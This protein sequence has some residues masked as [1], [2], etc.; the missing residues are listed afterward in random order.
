MLLL[1]HGSGSTEVQL[2]SEHNSAIWSVL[3]R[4][5]LRYLELHGDKD[6]A[7]LLAETP[8]ELCH[9]TNGFGDEFEL[10]YLQT[11]VEGYLKFDADVTKRKNGPNPYRAIANALSELNNAIRFIVVDIAKDDAEAVS[12]PR[13]E[14]TS[15]TVER[16]L[17]DFEA[18]VSSRGGAVS[19]VDRIHTALHAYLETVCD[20]AGIQHNEGADIATLF[21]LIRQQHPKLQKHPPGVEAQKMLRAL[22]Q[23]VDTL[24]PVRNQKS[25]AHPNDDLL[26]EPEAMLVANAAKGLLHYLNVKLR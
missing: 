4:N 1:Y 18:L 24:N 26:E 13:L 19:G 16:A 2:V 22:A 6:A 14:I 12:T 10:L 8:F 25:M 15:A 17:N 20:G 11:S 23:I 9:G 3:K 21:Q 5:V 7:R